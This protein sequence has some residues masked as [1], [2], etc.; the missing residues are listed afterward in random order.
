M[1]WG[2]SRSLGNSN[3]L[4]VAAPLMMLMVRCDAHALPWP[5][6]QPDPVALASKLHLSR[7]TLTVCINKLRVFTAWLAHQCITGKAIG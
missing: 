1:Q 2:R 3:G 4:P 6:Y 7:S 5:V